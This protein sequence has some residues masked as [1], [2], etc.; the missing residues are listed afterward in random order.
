MSAVAIAARLRLSAAA[1]TAAALSSRAID[2]GESTG[3]GDSTRMVTIAR[4]P[5]RQMSALTGA[6]RRQDQEI[7]NRRERGEAMARR[8]AAG[9]R[10]HP[11]GPG[12]CLWGRLQQQRDLELQR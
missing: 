12:R 7:E 4:I 9:A 6:V 2:M 11:R 10:G 5:R 8:S 3:R 1:E